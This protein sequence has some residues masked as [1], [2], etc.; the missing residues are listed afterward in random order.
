MA[1]PRSGSLSETDDVRIIAIKPLLSPSLLLDELPLCSSSTQMI[2]DARRTISSIIRGDDDRVVA[3]VGPCSV[4][5]VKAAREY[6]DLLKKLS[7]EIS[8]RRTNDA[9]NLTAFVASNRT[10]HTCTRSLVL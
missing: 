4:H 1:H 10:T 9:N 5:D 8:V 7:L 3:V 6:A 2:V